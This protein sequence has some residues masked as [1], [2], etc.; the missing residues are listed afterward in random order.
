MPRSPLRDLL[1]QPLLRPRLH[2]DT[3]QLP[4]R[5]WP[6]TLALCRRVHRNGSSIQH[7]RIETAD[8]L[9]VATAATSGHR[10]IAGARRDTACDLM[11]I[12]WST[13]RLAQRANSESVTGRVRIRVFMVFSSDQIVFTAP[14]GQTW[15]ATH[16]NRQNASAPA[17]QAQQSPNVIAPDC[18]DVGYPSLRANSRLP[19]RTLERT[20]RGVFDL[21]IFMLSSCSPAETTPANAPRLRYQKELSSMFF[22]L[23]SNPVCAILASSEVLN[24]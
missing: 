13:G 14:F 10:L 4:S 8:I 23:T 20:N 18:S 6:A 1:P 9:I 16:P 3:Q 11:L 21:T 24:S 15:L 7:F 22:R 19:S 12:L 17:R 2:P 5:R